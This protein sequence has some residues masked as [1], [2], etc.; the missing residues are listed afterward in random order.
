M[1]LG[2]ASWYAAPVDHHSGSTGGEYPA[3]R[4]PQPMVDDPRVYAAGKSD[5]VMGVCVHPMAQP[6]LGRWP[7]G[8]SSAL[9]RAA[10]QP[11]P[12]EPIAG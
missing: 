5:R 4:W 2:D 8:V 9:P 10:R 3:S 1:A 7:T 6:R 11:W 12:G